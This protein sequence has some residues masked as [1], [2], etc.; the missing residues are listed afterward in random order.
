MIFWQNTRSGGKKLREN[1][2]QQALKKRIKQLIPGCTIFKNDPTDMQ[3]VPDLVVL[4]KDRH[5]FLEVKAS[6]KAK[7][8]PNQDWYIQEFG[9]HVFSSFI[10]PENESE[11]LDGLQRALRD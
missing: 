8:Q 2:Y 7:H 9:K 4:Y 3:G 6:A 10:Y 5:A 1:D 11:V